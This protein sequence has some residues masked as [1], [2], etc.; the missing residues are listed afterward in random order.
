[1][2]GS[3]E[4]ILK[5]HAGRP[6]IVHFWGLRCGPCVMEL[7]E[8]GRLLKERPDLNLVLV[9]ADRLPPDM[10]LLTGTLERA[11]LTRAENW[12]FQ[13]KSFRSLGAE[14]DPQ[15]RGEIPFTLLVSPK[16]DIETIVGSV[17]VADIEGWLDSQRQRGRALAPARNVGGFPSAPIEPSN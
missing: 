1:V 5:E 16:G 3:F 4:A 6:A 11:G 17:D 14:V 13:G 9:H 7:P 2:S 8:W 10:R 12:V 15:W